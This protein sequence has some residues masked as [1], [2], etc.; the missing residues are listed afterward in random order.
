MRFGKALVAAFAV[1]GLS[2]STALAQDYVTVERRGST[3]GTVLRNTIAGGLLGSAV[4]GGIILYEMEINDNDDYNWERTLAWGAAIGLG[5][6]LVWGIVDA[7]SGPDYASIA[8]SPVARSPVRDGQ[9]L[10]LDV[11][12]RDQSGREMFSVFSGRF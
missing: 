8:S 2:A 10:T 12:R 7:T 6:G 11:R 1:L 5:V 4:S 9:S 3:A